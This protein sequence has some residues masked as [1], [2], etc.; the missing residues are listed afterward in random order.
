[1]RREFLPWWLWF[2]III[3]TYHPLF[4]LIASGGACRYSSFPEIESKVIITQL[5]IYME[6]PFSL[7]QGT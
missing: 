6:S 4:M 1:M 2:W 3:V 5:W 7:Y